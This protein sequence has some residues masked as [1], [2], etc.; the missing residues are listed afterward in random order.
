ME[1]LNS[2]KSGT[3]LTDNPHFNKSMRECFLFKCSQHIYK[4]DSVETDH[5]DK[6]S[7]KHVISIKF[8]SHKEI[9]R[10]EERFYDSKTIINNKLGN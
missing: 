5:K 4:T 10:K 1:D 6:Y 2:I 7:P 9:N 3:E 8:S